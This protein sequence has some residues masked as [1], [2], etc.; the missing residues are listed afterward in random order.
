VIRYA[1]SGAFNEESFGEVV[2]P[3]LAAPAPSKAMTA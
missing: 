2:K 1:Q 3:L